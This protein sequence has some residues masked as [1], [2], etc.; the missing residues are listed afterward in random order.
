MAKGYIWT[1][2]CHHMQKKHGAEAKQKQSTDEDDKMEQVEASCSIVR[3]DASN[4]TA[5]ETGEE[6]ETGHHLQVNPILR[7][8][9]KCIWKCWPSIVD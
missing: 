9:T 1:S 6:S 7:L 5:E 8:P 2:Q 4:S 3:L